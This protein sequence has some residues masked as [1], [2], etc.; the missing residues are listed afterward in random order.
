MKK[1]FRQ[2]E[3]FYFLT[4]FNKWSKL[5]DLMAQCSVRDVR[6]GPP[7]REL[8]NYHS[9]PFR[10]YYETKSLG[11]VFRSQGCKKMYVGV[12][13]HLEMFT[14]DRSSFVQIDL[15]Q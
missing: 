4:I 14:I 2:F 7:D 1:E 9:P 15:V 8:Y 5:I 3:K 13:L 11:S 12:C 10:D 6:R